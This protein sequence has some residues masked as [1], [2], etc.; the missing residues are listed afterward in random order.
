MAA[1]ASLRRGEHDDLLY[2]RW[3]VVP[4]CLFGGAPRRAAPC[5]AATGCAAH[6]ATAVTI[7]AAAIAGCPSTFATA[8]ACSPAT[9]AFAFATPAP[10]GAGTPTVASTTAGG[11]PSI[12]VAQPASSLPTAVATA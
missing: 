6:R 3:L 4:A 8:I 1:T 5:A 11:A 2:D 12:P 9:A 10:P 7:F